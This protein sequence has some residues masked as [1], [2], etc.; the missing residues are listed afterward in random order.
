MFGKIRGRYREGRQKPGSANASTGSY[1]P[2][3]GKLKAAKARLGE[4]FSQC[5]DL[6]LREI[7]CGDSGRMRILVA[8]IDGFIDKRVLNQDVI[9]PVLDFLSNTEPQEGS[10]LKRLLE[11][12]VIN[13]DIKE[14][15]DMGQAVDGIISGEALIFMDGE[16]RAL[17]VGVKSL[18]GRQVEEPDT[19]TS[20]R[21]SREGLF[22]NLLTNMVLYESRIKNRLRWRSCSLE[23]GQD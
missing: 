5:S 8:Y 4:I 10:V 23:R 3:P 20:I 17:L 1:G 19:E 18:Q 12:V 6:I 9:H 15:H 13:S 2:I 16:D 11:C 22:E 14:A 7:S 21:G